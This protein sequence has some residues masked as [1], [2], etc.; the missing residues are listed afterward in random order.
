MKEKKI[1]IIKQLILTAAFPK[2]KE[3]GKINKK[4][5]NNKTAFIFEL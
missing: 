1:I 5:F 3:I 2:I 4:N